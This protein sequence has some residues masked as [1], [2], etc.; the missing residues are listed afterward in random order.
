MLFPGD[1]VID[2]GSGT[3]DVII[4]YD[5]PPFI[6]PITGEIF[7]D[8]YWFADY[9]LAD[10]PVVGGGSGFG[11]IFGTAYVSLGLDPSGTLTN[12]VLDFASFNIF[13]GAGYADSWNILT[14]AY[15]T[16]ALTIA[17]TALKDI[18]ISGS[19]ADQIQGLAGDD[20]I[21]AGAGD[22]VIEG[23]DGFDYLDGGTGADIMRGGAD[24]DIYIV[25]SAG[26][27]IV[28]TADGGIDTVYALVS[29]VVGANVENIFLQGTV[30]IDATG[31]ALGNQITG[32]DQANTLSGLDGADRL[33]G[34]GGNDR[35]VGGNGNDILSGGEGTD[36]MLGGAGNDTYVV[37]ER[38]DAV[39]E[40]ANGGFDTIETTLAT[41]TIGAN[42]EGLT[43]TSGQAFIGVGNDVA[44]TLAGG[45]GNDRLE[46]RAGD[47]RIEGRNGNDRL[48][49]GVGA[50]FLIGGAG[51]DTAVYTAATSAIVVNLVTGGTA[52]E[53]AGDRFSGVENIDGTA[54]AD[55]ITGDSA[56]N[57]LT[58]NAGDDVLDGAG[59]NDLL[60][61]GAGADTLIGGAGIDTLSYIS[62]STALFI[63]IGA[64]ILTGVG[65]AA[66][67]TISGF[68]NVV[69]GNASD[70]IIGSAAA[71]ILSGGP[72]R[73]TISGLGGNDTIIG[74]TG[75]DILAGG[76]G[77][78][79]LSYEN[80]VGGVTINLVTSIVSGGDAA[81]DVVSGFEYA[82][83]GNGAD[84]II[85]STA[86]E[87]L[88]G[89]AGNDTIDGGAGGD[90]ISGGAGADILTGGTGV[91]ALSYATSTQ[92]VRLNLEA[93]FFTGGDAQGDSATGFEH[94]IGSNFDD[95]IVGDAG[96]NR[97][98]GNAGDDLL[99]GSGGNDLLTGG[100]GR[101][102]FTFIVPGHDVVTDFSTI[103]DVMLF[104]ISE[105][106]DTY[107][108]VIAIAS[109]SGA[110][111]VF[112]FDALTTVTLQN[113][114]LTALSETNFRFFF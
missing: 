6:D 107:E 57:Q 93:N 112:T 106:F 66:G 12:Y 27:V 114:D 82:I 2:R 77:V 5:A 14:A 19:G 10:G 65:D 56:G 64:D 72:G 52:G 28:E 88:T 30:P 96:A 63:D 15:A 101:D 111:V 29:Y 45:F 51:I 59:G 109:Q 104:S 100:A 9:R 42:V 83:G 90:I 79:T 40:T 43:H 49:G 35:L 55:T 97:L 53:A 26:D 24:A 8:S 85:G 92:G 89:G 17:G 60:I 70:V 75:A 68:E 23:G 105:N 61:G 11:S 38:T 50:D 80:S 91:D 102:S 98:V 48:T 36:T 81:G 87:V 13:G 3:F 67:D 76:D 37:N 94:V 47:D 18:I 16:D 69:G 86:A 74:G 99:D 110:N 22:D 34:L 44:N 62:T 54:F 113:T 71:N 39:V 31:N 46:G 20:W 25:D 7:F 32:T 73:D 58:G 84:V 33:T 108:E 41:Y 4:D 103:D 1:V 21:D 78:D 95:A